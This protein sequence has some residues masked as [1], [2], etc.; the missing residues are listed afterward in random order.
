MCEKGPFGFY[1]AVQ[2]RY[3][4]VGFL[5]YFTSGNLLFIIIGTPAVI[6]AFLGLFYYEKTFD[7][8]QKG[9]Y[10]SFSILFVITVFFTNIQSSTRFFCSHP[11]F[12]Y[13]MACLSVKLGLVKLWAVFYWIVG[14]FMYVVG[15]P[16]T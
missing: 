3:W 13:A 8:R 6:V 7:L 11:Y 16:W 12:Y 2:E 4:N 1:G 5:K 14:I 9:L 10:L 15:F